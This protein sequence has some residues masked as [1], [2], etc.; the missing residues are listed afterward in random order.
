M[1]THVMSCGAARVAVLFC[2]VPLPSGVVLFAGGTNPADA[3]GGCACTSK[4]LNLVAG[5]NGVG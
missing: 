2:S 5:G 3:G 4:M 1:T